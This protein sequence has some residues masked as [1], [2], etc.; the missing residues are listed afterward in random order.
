MTAP[1]LSVTGSYQGGRNVRLTRSMMS[2][3]DVSRDQ[4]SV[5]SGSSVLVS[6]VTER[7]PGT[8]LS[9]NMRHHF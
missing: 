6:L 1:L 8:L 2:S 5:S 7:D 4:P 3:R 9:V